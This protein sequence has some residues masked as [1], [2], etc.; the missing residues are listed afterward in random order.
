MLRPEI[1]RTAGDIW[2]FLGK[3]GKVSLTDLLTKTKIKPDTVHQA[4]GWLAR[5]DKI[6]F[7]QQARTTYVSLTSNE[8]NNYRQTQSGHC[9][10]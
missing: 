7:T 6:E 9:C 5:E 8:L 3:S 10:M 2:K 1:G 4:I